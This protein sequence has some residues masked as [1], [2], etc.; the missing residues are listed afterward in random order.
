M[1]ATMA[2]SV[3]NFV[4]GNDVR[5]YHRQSVGIEQIGE[6]FTL[7]KKGIVGNLALGGAPPS[8]A[9]LP[10][11]A[12][13][14]APGRSPSPL[15]VNDVT[16]PLLDEQGLPVR[17]H[18]MIRFLSLPLH[19][20]HLNS[21]SHRSCAA[22]MFVGGSCCSIPWNVLQLWRPSQCLTES[23][24]YEFGAGERTTRCW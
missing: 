14:P 13:R 23:R 6:G 9:G 12:P 15:G 20:N 1:C 3:F 11:S 19:L 17:F 21:R 7:D 18:L 22:D 24:K 16:R 4:R 10:V 8:S 2:S 5:C